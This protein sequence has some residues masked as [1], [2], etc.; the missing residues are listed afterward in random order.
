MR[1]VS[2]MTRMKR[3]I[4]TKNLVRELANNKVDALEM[5]REA[6]SN[7]VDHGASSVWIRSFRGAPGKTT[8]DILLIND[9]E[10]MNREQL[11][12][13]WGVSSSVKTDP[14]RA[15][16]YKGH[17]SKLFFS[18]RRLSVASRHHTA[19]HW[20][21]T[22]L[23][24]PLESSADELEIR[25]LPADHLLA[26]ELAGVGLTG[27][28]G[29]AILV[30]DCQFHDADRFFDRHAIESYC[31][32]FTIVGD[33]RSGLFKTRA[34][35][36]AFVSA[37][38]DLEQLRVGERP[39][40]VLTVYLR[41]N[42][43]P[44]YSALGAA[45]SGRAAQHL[46]AWDHDAKVWRSSNTPGMAA[47]GHRF[48]DHFESESASG[49]RRVRD[50]RTALCLTDRSGFTED[51]KYALVMRVEGQRRQLDTYK[52]GSRQSIRGIFDFDTRFGLWL[53]RDFIPIVQRNDLL[54]RALS[55]ATEKSKKRLRFDLSRTRF[56]QIFIN[57][58][59][60]LLTANRNDVAN[61][62]QHEESI[63]EMVAGSI[64]E[65]LKKDA[66]REWI[67]NL[68]TAITADRRNK[69]IEAMKER[70]DRVTNWFRKAGQ[71]VEPTTV[72]LERIDE[73]DSLRLPRPSSEQELFY[74]YAVLSGRYRVPMRVL[75][76][77]TR[78][79]VDAVAQVQDRMLFTPPMATARVE[80]KYA[81]HGNR[82]I[83][84][85]FEAIDAI[86]C[87]E[88]TSTGNLPEAG[89]KPTGGTLRKRASPRTQSKLDT[90]EVEYTDS[91]GN[92]K[93]IPV[94]ALSRLFTKK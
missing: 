57:N 79:G 15:I 10:G 56:W 40:S 60:F 9:G 34:E 48:A 70:V 91:K 72:S 49:A 29:V 93:I 26:T 62:L 80:F 13:F 20:E 22:S 75:E 7:A 61:R 81:L 88:V 50:D 21:L 8:T 32:W 2:T 68:Q 86:I 94:L 64:A 45:K 54:L 30:Q 24:N 18:A 17:G 51:P 4:D 3:T 59:D 78:L 63:V 82:A 25:E 76:Y 1:Y 23:D 92:T 84:H 69:E 52:E 67:E 28:Q 27:K 77:D 44:D 41:I 87:W 31:D 85:F 36:H 47:F 16:G 14:S 83:G 37:G 43:E 66:F 38:K 39:L 11:S 46:D 12:A 89:D 90:H 65:E 74:L 33:V 5:V 6:L 53:C 58:Q 71:D 35:F 73:E 55:R 42:G 19:A